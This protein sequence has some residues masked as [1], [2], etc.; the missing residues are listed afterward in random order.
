LGFCL[1]AFIGMRDDRFTTLAEVNEKFGDVIVGQVPEMP[2]VRGQN[3]L[4]LL[5]LEDERDMF[6]ESY[7]S[8]RSAILFMPRE[9]DPPKILLITSALPD[10]GKS[11]IAANLARTL[12]LGGARVLLIDGDLRKGFLHDLLGM[13]LQP[14]LVDLLDRPEDMDAIIQSDAL[15]NFYFLSRGKSVPNPGDLF[16]SPK[17][18]QLFARL[19][20]KF[21]YVLIDSSPIFAADDA[22]SLAPKVDG[23]LFVVRSRF[24]PA[25]AVKEALELLSQRQVRVLGLIFNRAETTGRSYYY[26]KNPEYYRPQKTA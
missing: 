6:A 9:G 3:R 19:R 15:P 13:R 11:T 1:V 22:A 10:E 17:L 18:G 25:G 12:A 26:Y 20:K 4:P 8:L 14:G 23:T 16:L 5:V 2:S 7:R 24:S 21:D